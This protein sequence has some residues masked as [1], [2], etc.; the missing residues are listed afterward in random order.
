MIRLHPDSAMLHLK[1]EQAARFSL[2]VCDSKFFLKQ[3][4]GGVKMLVGHGLG[5]SNGEDFQRC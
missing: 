2:H 3:R 5:D 4:A 1:K